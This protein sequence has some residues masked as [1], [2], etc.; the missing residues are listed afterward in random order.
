VYVARN[1]PPEIWLTE[2]SYND[3]KLI[4]KG[5]S[6]DYTNQGFFLDN[7]KKS[8]FFDKN[9]TYNKIDASSLPEELKKLAPFEITAT[10][11]RFE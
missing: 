2:V 7:L 4:F 10:I 9:I 8:I 3:N 11:V 6:L 1:I 5:L